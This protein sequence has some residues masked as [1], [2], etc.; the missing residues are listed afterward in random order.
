MGVSPIALAPAGTGQVAGHQ[1]QQ[2]AIV[3]HKHAS[4]L[5]GQG[6]HQLEE[7]DL[8]LGAGH[9]CGTQALEFGDS[10]GGCKVRGSWLCAWTGARGDQRWCQDNR[11]YAVASQAFQT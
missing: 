6:I 11:T 7:H 2:L 3:R 5:L 10:T 9:T 1:A 8:A 4:Q